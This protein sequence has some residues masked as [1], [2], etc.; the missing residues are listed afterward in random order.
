MHFPRLEQPRVGRML[1]PMV[2]VGLVGAV[3]TW[4]IGGLGGEAR[5]TRAEWTPAGTIA[6]LGCRLDV[7][8]DDRGERVVEVHEGTALLEGYGR[9]V[10]V[11]AGA[12][13]AMRVG[14]GPGTPSRADA[15]AALR[16]ALDRIDFQGGG[17]A[18]LDDVLAHARPVDR[19]T[20]EV[21]ADRFPGD[22]GR[23]VRTRL[24]R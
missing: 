2:L 9:A 11:P 16:R 20:L 5:T 10:R 1:V 19:I 7:S 23:A 21:L 8:V 13:C 22:T 14:I 24:A 15:P 6:C 4:V 17:G 18:A 12:R 3:G